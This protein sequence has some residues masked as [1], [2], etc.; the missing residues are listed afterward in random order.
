MDEN[1]PHP[2]I[3]LPMSNIFSIKGHKLFINIINLTQLTFVSP[4]IN[5]QQQTFFNSIHMTTFQ[6]LLL[7]TK[8]T[9]LY[10]YS[11]S[12]ICKAIFFFTFNFHNII[13]K[14]Y[15]FSSLANVY[16]IKT[17]QTS[18]MAKKKFCLLLYSIT[19]I[20]PYS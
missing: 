12:Y 4:S 3:H 13:N 6:L 8:R 15:K 1:S 17:L 9:F 5:I 14:S 11:T 16:H 19:K 2:F 18:Y 20:H 10:T 7:F